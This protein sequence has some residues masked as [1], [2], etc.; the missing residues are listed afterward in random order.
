MGAVLLT[1]LLLLAVGVAVIGIALASTDHKQPSFYLLSPSFAFLLAWCISLGLYFLGG[2]YFLQER[3][4]QALILST[5]A[6][7]LPGLLIL[8]QAAARRGA[9]S[10]SAGSIRDLRVQRLEFVCLTG[11]ALASLAAILYVMAAMSAAGLSVTSIFESDLSVVRGIM[12]TSAYEVPLEV[13]LLGQLKYL[14]YFVPIIFMRLWLERRVPFAIVVVS[15]LLAFAHPVISLERSGIVR[16]VVLFG[17]AYLLL[18]KSFFRSMGRVGLV[19]LI[20]VAPATLIVPSIRGQASEAVVTPY[21]Y[22]VGA[23]SGLDAFVSGHDGPVDVLEEQE[24]Y[25]SR[26]GYSPGDSPFGIETATEIYRICNLLSLC[27]V[28]IPNHKEYVHS[29]IMT[30]TYTG[31]RSEG[32]TACISRQNSR[33]WHWC[34]ELLASSPETQLP[35]PRQRRQTVRPIV[36][37]IESIIQ[38]PMF[39]SCWVSGDL[40]R[41]H[42]S[43][44]SQRCSP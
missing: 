3:T 20:V 44:V 1:F 27:D 35:L 11:Q 5:V 40:C 8:Q 21:D 16:L 13:R 18:S 10:P 31:I 25:I 39:G 42:Q 36:K 43:H 6:F 9:V 38:K 15:L 29:P 22:V 41:V 37:G 12:A 4:V 14:N 2:D 30:N 33:D 28:A 34:Q 17:C 24:I 19:A 32:R 23:L 7:V 26:E